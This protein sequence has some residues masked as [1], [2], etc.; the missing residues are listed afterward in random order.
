MDFRIWILK[1]FSN[2]FNFLGG[3]DLVDRLLEDCKLCANKSS[4]QG[5]DEI[6]LLLKYCEIYNVLD[7]VNIVNRT[8]FFIYF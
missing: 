4:K 8:F 5:I 1:T 2:L 3:Q 7:K 6:K